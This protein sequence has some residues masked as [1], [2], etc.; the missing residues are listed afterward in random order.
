MTSKLMKVI[1][2]IGAVCLI[3]GLVIFWTRESTDTSS[4]EE[5]QALSTLSVS[6]R[7]PRED[8]LVAN[9]IPHLVMEVDNPGWF[10]FIGFDE[11][12]LVEKYDKNVMWEDGD[13]KRNKSNFFGPGTCAFVPQRRPIQPN[14][15]VYGLVFY[16]QG[17]P[18]ALHYN[19]V[20]NFHDDQEG[21]V[22]VSLVKGDRTAV[23]HHAQ[24]GETRIDTRYLTEPY[25]LIVMAAFQLVPYAPGKPL[26][27]VPGVGVCKTPVEAELAVPTVPN[28][29][30]PHKEK[31]A[32][33]KP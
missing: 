26:P 33:S 1:I 19:I 30:T 32:T 18:D 14:R 27:R 11:E 9:G 6:L 25:R 23:F 28:Q 4:L 17:G 8:E 2:G 13:I 5:S 7:W 22:E 15:F 31:P 12:I 21:F 20:R 10:V 29:E 3:C 24:L 16:L